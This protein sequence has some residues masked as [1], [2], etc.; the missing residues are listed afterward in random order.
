MGPFNSIFFFG[1]LWVESRLSRDEFCCAMGR[2]TKVPDPGPV[3]SRYGDRTY[4]AVW[5]GASSIGERD[6]ISVMLQVA[7]SKPRARESEKLL[8]SCRSMRLYTSSIGGMAV[9]DGLEWV[10]RRES[11]LDPWKPA[12]SKKNRLS[13]SPIAG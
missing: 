5:K 2:T 12:T 11:I 6:T 1:S 13:L 7:S 9:S 4:H 8:H 3:S 10:Q